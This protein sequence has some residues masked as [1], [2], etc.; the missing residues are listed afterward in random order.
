MMRYLGQLPVQTL[1]SPSQIQQRIQ[2]LGT[3]ISQDYVDK[4]TVL[5]V[6]LKGAL[7]FAADLMREIN[8]VPLA[9]STIAVSSY[10]GTS[11]TGTISVTQPCP[12][13]LDDKHVIIVEDIV[14]TG[15]SIRF[16][17]EYLNKQFRLQS[18]KVCCLLSKPS[19]HQNQVQLDYVG[20]DIEREFVIGYGLDLDGR[21]R[22]LNEIVQVVAPLPS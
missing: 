8:N 20:F 13:S 21:Y 12:D 18:L 10:H 4:D 3:A 11:S 22:E 17:Q 15:A 16:L 19:V 7:V 9:F 6:V 2:A 1:L 14:D 5:L